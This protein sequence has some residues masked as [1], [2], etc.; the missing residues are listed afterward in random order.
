MTKD[1]P[2]SFN[3]IFEIPFQEIAIERK[4]GEG[5]FS[6]VF[7]AKWKEK[8]AAV[9]QFKY[10]QFTT[11]IM[12]NFLNESGIMKTINHPNVIKLYGISINGNNEDKKYC[13]I[14]EYL[15]R[16]SLSHILHEKKIKLD[17]SIQLKLCQN[18]A[19]GLNYLHSL[20]PKIIHRDLKSP[21]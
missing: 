11:S 21:K 15:E 13:L 10:G 7:K 14:L 8:L 16:G 12:K 20:R 4:I 5:G 9:K 17:F 3:G 19:L 6:E 1:S 18:I 2:S